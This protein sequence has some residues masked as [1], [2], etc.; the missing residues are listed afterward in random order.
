MSRFLGTFTLFRASAL[1]SS[2]YYKRVPL[3]IFIEIE[4]ERYSYM[5]F[6]LTRCPFYDVDTQKKNWTPN[7]YLDEIEP[8][9]AW[10]R[11]ERTYLKNT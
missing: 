7:M 5:Y 9:L 3:I 1:N 2:F 4:K 8:V 11:H 6:H 10:I